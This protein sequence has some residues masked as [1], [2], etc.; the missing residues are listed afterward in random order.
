MS[1]PCLCHTYTWPP[2]YQY[3][4]SHN[5][6]GT[7]AHFGSETSDGYFVS[8]KSNHP[9]I[10]ATRHSPQKYT[11]MLWRPGQRPGPHWEAQSVLQ[12]FYSRTWRSLLG[13]EEEGRI[14][15]GRRSE[16]KG[17]LRKGIRGELVPKRWVVSAPP[18]WGCPGII[19][20]LLSWCGATIN[21]G[22]QNSTILYYMERFIA[23]SET[24]TWL[25]SGGPR[26][27]ETGTSLLY[28]IHLTS[29]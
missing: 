18:K 4:S 23:H 29:S 6:V 20:W 13:R 19:G 2:L 5:V 22:G 27:P 17:R 9:T 28:Y 8:Y 1:V 15:K 11:K 12:T 21:T 7:D 16:G 10:V 14:W 25:T 26:W 24:D 3:V